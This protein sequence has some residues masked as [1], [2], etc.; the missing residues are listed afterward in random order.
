MI[1]QSQNLLR[2]LHS[3]FNGSTWERSCDHSVGRLDF[4]GL[5]GDSKIFNLLHL[6]ARFRASTSNHASVMSFYAI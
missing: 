2:H 5:K 1:R 6:R 3:R 4:S